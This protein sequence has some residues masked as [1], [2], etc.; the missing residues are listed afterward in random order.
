[1]SRDEAVKVARDRV[2]ALRF[3]L[4]DDAGDLLEEGTDDDPLVYLHGH[5]ELLDAIEA[6]LEGKEVGDRTT[7]TL[8]PEDGFGPREDDAERT[9]PRDLIPED[10]PLEP[11]TA[12]AIEDDGE[13]TPVWVVRATDTHVVVSLCHPYAGKT[14]T[15]ELEVLK[16]RDATEG[17][18]E[19]GH[20]H[21][22]EGHHH[23]H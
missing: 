22:L 12:F 19:H 5:G 11:G 13:V 4:K 20:S 10:E 9:L 8:P 7:L 1:M 3:T 16:I 14:V 21:G 18:L 6:A 17:E 2:V 15:F 23:H